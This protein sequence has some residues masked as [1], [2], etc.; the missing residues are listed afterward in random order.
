[1]GNTLGR[2][3]ERAEP[4]NV[5]TIVRE[6][7]KFIKAD[8]TFL[9]DTAGCSGH[10][11]QQFYDDEAERVVSRFD[12]KPARVHEIGPEVGVDAVRDHTFPACRT[13]LGGPTVKLP[14]ALGAKLM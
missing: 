7:G 13:R 6:G 3:L 11:A 12:V 2:T 1:M 5:Y 9:E 14:C 8:P 10:S 4:P